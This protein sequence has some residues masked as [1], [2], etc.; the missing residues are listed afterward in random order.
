MDYLEK[1]T[2]RPGLLFLVHAV[3]R[4]AHLLARR[5]TIKQ[6]C[7]LALRFASELTQHIFVEFP[8]YRQAGFLGAS[9]ICCR[10]FAIRLN[11]DKRVIAGVSYIF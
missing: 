1:S 5:W 11:K 9:M 3:M 7:E 4:D 6:K 2:I 10:A 8:A